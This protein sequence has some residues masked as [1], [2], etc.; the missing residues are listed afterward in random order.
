MDLMSDIIYL[1]SS[2]REKINVNEME[3]GAKV[4]VPGR[5]PGRVTTVG[6]EL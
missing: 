3:N 2:I 1:L 4:G 6:E 5:N